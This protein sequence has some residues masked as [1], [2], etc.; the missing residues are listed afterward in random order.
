MSG[1]GCRRASHISEE[2]EL[3]LAVDLDLQVFSIQDRWMLSI[4]KVREVSIGTRNTSS[5]R[6]RDGGSYQL[7]SMR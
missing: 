2:I 4:Q 6:I 7:R 5:S 1:A 3:A